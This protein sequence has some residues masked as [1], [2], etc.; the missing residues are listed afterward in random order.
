MCALIGAQEPREGVFS[1]QS[2]DPLLCGVEGVGTGGVHH[3][4]QGLPG[5]CIQV[6][7]RTEASLHS[8]SQPFPLS[9]YSAP[10]SC[11]ASGVMNW[12]HILLAL[13]LEGA[14]L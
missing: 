13:A 3:T 7:L 2:V 8:C 9:L 1:H 12:L 14:S 4:Q 6:H 5:L 11:G 10:T